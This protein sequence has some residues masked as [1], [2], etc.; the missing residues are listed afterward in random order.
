M[1]RLAVKTPQAQV[2][3]PCRVSANRFTPSPFVL[4]SLA[5]LLI[6]VAENTSGAAWPV[7]HL[8]RG[9]GAEDAIGRV[10]ARWTGRM[11]G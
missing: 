3:L 5:L 11:S 7:L 4:C 6:R 2:C 1:V 10:V 8:L 9:L